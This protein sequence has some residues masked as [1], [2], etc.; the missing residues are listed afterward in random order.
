MSNLKKEIVEGINQIKLLTN[1]IR[2]LKS[3]NQRLK[4][5]IEET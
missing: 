2:A 1:E 4:L 3:D 5:E